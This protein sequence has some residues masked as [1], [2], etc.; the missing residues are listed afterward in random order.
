MLSRPG[1]EQVFATQQQLGSPRTGTCARAV[2]RLALPTAER[3][4]LVHRNAAA[5][6]DRRGASTAALRPP[7]VRQPR[8]ALAG[9]LAVRKDASQSR[10]SALSTR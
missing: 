10:S 9:L 6:N 3:W 1:P 2:L 5:E 7:A 8:D 4:D